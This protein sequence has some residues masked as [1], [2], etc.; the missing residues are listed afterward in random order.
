V[1]YSTLL[2]EAWLVVPSWEQ[3]VNGPLS[4][5][6]PKLKVGIAFVDPAARDGDEKARAL[7]TPARASSQSAGWDLVSANVASIHIAPGKW[8]RIPTG[9]SLELA[10]GYEG[11]IRPRSGLAV[12]HG[13]TVLNAPG[14]IDSDYRGEVSVVLIN[15]GDAVFQITRGMRIAQLIVAR[16][17]SVELVPMENLSSTERGD[18]GF[19]ST[20]SY[21][22][23]GTKTGE[24][25]SK[26]LV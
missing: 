14:T 20:G 23:L 19:G 21:G 7:L 25:I 18:K 10:D 13:V 26:D 22:A 15:Q 2:V 24:D 16:V 17:E 5:E 8:A 3:A 4:E 11:Q 9:I 1:P 6:A 12:R